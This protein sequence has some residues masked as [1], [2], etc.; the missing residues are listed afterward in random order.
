MVS[1]L[2]SPTFE[3][4]SG[5]EVSRPTLESVP[6]F[7]FLRRKELGATRREGNSSKGSSLR[8][9]RGRLTAV[10]RERPDR[11][12]GFRCSMGNSRGREESSPDL[13][14][15]ESLSWRMLRFSRGFHGMG[16]V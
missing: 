7:K 1:V 10:R 3:R 5:V 9:L 12:L 8:L 4:S 15:K 13:D 2:S 14:A 6:C 11:G 16:G